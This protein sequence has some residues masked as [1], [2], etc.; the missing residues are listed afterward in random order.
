MF[1]AFQAMLP[2]SREPGESDD[3]KASSAPA[4]APVAW[5]GYRW[6]SAPVNTGEESLAGL[7][8]KRG[9]TGI[10]CARALGAKN[11]W[12]LAGC[13]TALARCQRS[14]EVGS[15]RLSQYGHREVAEPLNVLV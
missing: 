8:R 11:I 4:I 6:P 7:I 3:H 5:F 2:T 1:G 12:L 9:R 13:R 15:V 14:V 10:P